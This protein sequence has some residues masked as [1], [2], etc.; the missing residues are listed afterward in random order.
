MPGRPVVVVV[1][2]LD[3]T[4]GAGISADLMT[5][6][7]TGCRGRAVAAL[8]TAQGEGPVEA[9]PVDPDFLGRQLDRAC[10]GV[11]VAALKCGALGS[12][13]QVER[14]SRLASGL[15]SVPLVV[16]PVIRATRGGTLLDDAGVDA[17]ERLLVPRALVVTPNL[18]EA[19]ILT[20]LTDPGQAARALVEA[21][22]RWALVTGGHLG[23]EPHDLLAGPGGALLRID[24]RRIDVA[25]THGTGCVLASAL[26]SGLALGL[27]V[28]SACRRAKRLVE[29]A[30]ERSP[31]GGPAPDLAGLVGGG[32]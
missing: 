6:A 29:R 5:L 13:P 4:S 9:L 2:G 22:A 8:L 18:E 10:R 11:D 16:D 24:G 12:A 17:L 27:D 31:A 1:G 28:P 30:L 23:G 25:Q 15:G 19:E 20:G 32:E 14:V 3:P 21:G 26:A 7:L